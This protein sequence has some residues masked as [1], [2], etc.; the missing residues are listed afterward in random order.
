MLGRLAPPNIV[1][2]N[3][4]T[5]HDKGRSLSPWKPHEEMARGLILSGQTR[6]SSTLLSTCVAALSLSP[7]K[8]KHLKI[9]LICPLYQASTRFSCYCSHAHSIEHPVDM[10]K[11]KEAFSRRMAMAGLKPH[12]RIGSSLSNFSFTFLEFKVLSFDFCYYYNQ[13]VI[14][15]IVLL[16]LSFRS[17]WW[18]R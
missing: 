7:T 2:L 18:S 4:S 9:A 10:I 17:F 5:F 16:A 1:Y 11:Y 12:H 15:E 6:T 13:K 3:V 14:F 8:C